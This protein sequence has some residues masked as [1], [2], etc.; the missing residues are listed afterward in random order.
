MLSITAKLG[1]LL[2]A[3]LLAGVAFANETRTTQTP[4]CFPTLAQIEQHLS[5]RVGAAQLKQRQAEL[6]G[7]R[8]GLVVNQSS[9][10]GHCHLVDALS[11]LNLQVTVIFTPEHGFR[12]DA[13]AGAAVA[14]SKDS[15]SGVPIYSLY[16]AQ[17]APTALQL[18]NVD[19][20]LFDLQDVG[21]RFYTYLSTLHY[22]MQAAATAK[23]PLWVLDRPNP[24]GRWLDG[25]L[26]K[27]EFS[28]FVGLHPI[29]LL[30][31]MTLGEL[32][33]MIKGEDWIT[34]AKALALTVLP[35]TQYRRDQPYDLP[36]APSPNLPNSQ[37]IAW[38]PT[39]ALFEGTAVS[40]GR[41]T[42]WPFQLLG[43]PLRL[44]DP[45]VWRLTP[46]STPGASLNPPWR[47][48]VIGAEDFRQ[49]TPEHGLMVEVWLEWQQRFAAN[50]VRLIDKPAFFDKLAGSSQL[51][52]QLE[53]GQT[54][55]QIRLSWQ[56]DLAAFARRRAPY[57]L[58][59]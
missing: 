18:A 10:L 26:L 2:L 27:S 59:P 3:G 41:G 32:A 58:Y 12:G 4:G 24:N 34:G 50:G 7:K 1:A 36:V 38:Y 37:A 9:R 49:R 13:D 30:H 45:A 56:A 31:G 57:L 46:I 14:D 16:G 47:N 42:A 15:S 48:T 22:V 39:L 54:A 8:L 5:A 35:V 43:H 20:L 33:R 19:V 55:A 21:T 53:Q 40:V 17:K 52:Q 51:R 44:E 11:E 28:S 25:P 6:K 23:L 29:P